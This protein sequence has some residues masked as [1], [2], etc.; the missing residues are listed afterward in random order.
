[1]SNNYVVASIFLLQPKDTYITENKII[2]TSGFDIAEMI[3][4][5]RELLIKNNYFEFSGYTIRYVNEVFNRTLNVEYNYWGSI[6]RSEI[7]NQME[8]NI[9]FEPW[10][11]ENGN[12]HMG[13]IDDSSGENNDFTLN[14]SLLGSGISEG[15]TIDSDL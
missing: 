1:M 3:E 8:G 15:S 13:E 7:E 9:D 5:E 14:K 4:I 10:L 12:V 2:N 6:N 11:D